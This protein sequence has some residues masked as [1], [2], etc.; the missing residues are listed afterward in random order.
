MSNDLPTLTRRKVVPRNRKTSEQVARLIVRDAVTRD[1]APGTPLPSEAVMLQYYGVSRASLREALRILEVH[2]LITIKSGPGGGPRIAAVN[3]ADF[4]RTMTF[5]YQ[6]SGATFRELAEA[7][8]LIE[9]MIA[10]QAAQR[11]PPEQVTRLKESI[12]A[13]QA[14]S[15]G[16]ESGYVD[17]A[18]Q[19]HDIV[20]Q[21]SGN[22]VLSLIGSSFEEIFTVYA[23]GPF[24]LK[25]ARR[26]VK[27]HAQIA[28][29]IVAGDA[30]LAERQ[31][32]DHLIASNRDM[33]TRYPA[34]TDTVVDWI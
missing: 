17:L 31:M 13:A 24:T 27:A 22:K 33:E 25:E 21:M 15:D 14:L 16:D 29:A 30:D 32:R 5:Y 1:M 12:E 23:T 26:V 28:E 8:L 3:A 6:V 10:R 9:P 7:R 2:G 18:L 19:F 11:R 34:L 4:G 20:A